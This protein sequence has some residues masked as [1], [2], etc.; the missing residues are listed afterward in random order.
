[1][2]HTRWIFLRL[3]LLSAVQYASSGELSQSLSTAQR[4]GL[5]SPQMSSALAAS[6][7]A[8]FQFPPIRPMQVPFEY[9]HVGAPLGH[10]ASTAPPP[11]QR[12]SLALAKRR[13]PNCPTRFTGF[14]NV[15]SEVPDRA[16]VPPE[17]LVTHGAHMGSGQV[18]GAAA[19]TDGIAA[20]SPFDA[21]PTPVH[22][23]THGVNMGSGHGPPALGMPE[24]LPQLEIATKAPT[25]ND[26]ASI[27][28]YLST[29]LYRCYA[30]F[31]VCSSF[32]VR[33]AQPPERHRVPVSPG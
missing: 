23:A 9:I 33:L 21:R 27:V 29:L 31:V 10:T 7:I 28:L 2:T 5:S 17:H 16:A 24:T 19:P 8:G 11:S 3:L 18:P 1:M 4:Y 15:V 26:E 25:N 32:G 6:P 14:Q 13:S 12:A 30:S 22:F 20:R